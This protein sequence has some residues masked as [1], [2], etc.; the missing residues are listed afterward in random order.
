MATRNGTGGRPSKGKRDQLISRVAWDLGDI[1]RDNAEAEQLSVSDYIARVL[2]REVGR[3][4]L[5]P[6]HNR[7]YSEQ[8]LPIS[9]VA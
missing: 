7:P 1:V 4:E 5:A 2:A 3:P 6:R 9:D 8:E